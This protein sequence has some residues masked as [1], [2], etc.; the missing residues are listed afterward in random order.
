VDRVLIA[1]PPAGTPGVANRCVAG[2]FVGGQ[3]SRMGGQPKG[4]LPAPEG[5]TL[6]ER[7]CRVLAGA[8]IDDVVLVGAQAAYAPLGLPMLDDAP[9]GTG[10]LGGMLALLGYAAGARAPFAIALA[11]DMPFVSA[12]LIARLRDAA[13]AAIVAPRRDG[14]WEPLCAR[15][16]WGAAALGERRVASGDYSLQRW[17]DQ[18]QA[19]ELSLS[20][21]EAQELR[22]WDTPTDMALARDA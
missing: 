17:L 12:G 18:G 13:P 3:S 6:V 7:C 8:G 2:V 5:G 21:E 9:P 15:Y 20:P 14:R 4:L 11:C 16:S 19:I 22:D 1:G 10:P